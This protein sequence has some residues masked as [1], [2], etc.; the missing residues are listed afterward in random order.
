MAPI[1]VFGWLVCVLLTI[2]FVASI[3]FLPKNAEAEDD[4]S[5]DHFRNGVPV[6]KQIKKES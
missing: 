4:R 3:V 2:S 1:D 6:K 5:T